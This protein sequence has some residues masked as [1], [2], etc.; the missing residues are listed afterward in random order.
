[1]SGRLACIFG[2]VV[3]RVQVFMANKHAYFGDVR[4]VKYCVGLKLP[5][6]TLSHQLS[7]LSLLSP[8]AFRSNLVKHLAK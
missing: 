1:M 2:L 6:L 5:L 7:A 8:F 3:T 4:N